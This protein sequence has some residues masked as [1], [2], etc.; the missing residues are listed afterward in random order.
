MAIELSEIELTNGFHLL[1]KVI[2]SRK[3]TGNINRYVK[4]MS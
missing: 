2:L 1:C 3:R 4:D